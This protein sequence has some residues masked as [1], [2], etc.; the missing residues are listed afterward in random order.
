MLQPRSLDKLGDLKK[1]LV[2]CLMPGQVLL[3]KIFFL[4]RSHNFD[5]TAKYVHM[6]NSIAVSSSSLVS[7][8]LLFSITSVVQHLFISYIQDRPAIHVPLYVSP[9]SHENSGVV[10]T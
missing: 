4:L 10:D 2:K 8:S 3:G 6:L 5:Y 1:K 7:Y 9:N